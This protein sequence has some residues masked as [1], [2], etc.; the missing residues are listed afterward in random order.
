MINKFFYQL[1]TKEENIMKTKSIFFQIILYGIVMN[2][3]AQIPLNQPTLLSDQLIQ[4]NMEQVK[5]VRIPWIKN[6]GQQHE[7]VGYYART[8]AG[9][10]FISNK[11]EI[12]YSIPVEGKGSFAMSEIFIR[13]NQ[14]VVK[15]MKVNGEKPSITKVNYFIGNN[16]EKWRTNVPTFQS[17]QLG[18][19]WPGIKVKLKAH[20]NNIEKLFYIA[21]NAD[22]ATIRI[23]LTGIDDI[24]LNESGE[25][26][27]N[28]TEGNLAFSKPLAFQYINGIKHLVHV[29]Y[30]IDYNAYGF[31]VENFDPAYALVID[32]LI[33]STY[34]GGS[35]NDFCS[36]LAIDNL[37]NI[38]VT[39]YTESPDFPSSGYPYNG[40]TDIFICEL[41]NDLN[42]LLA[43]TFIGGTSYD[44]GFS[45]VLGSGGNI[46]ISG[47]TSSSNFPTT[48]GCFDNTFNGGRDNFIS[49]LSND[50]SILISS[51]YIGGSDYEKAYSVSL[52]AL[53]KVFIT[54][55]TS[56]SDYPTIIGSFSTTH[57]G[58]ND[59]F[60][61]KL[62][63]DLTVLESSTFIGGINDDYSN[64][65]KLDLFG[66]VFIGGETYSNN[67]P[68][69]TG[70]FST[71]L[72]GAND[73]F[74][75]KLDNGLG[76]VL[77]ATFVGGSESENLRQLKL[78][79]L[80]NIF[81][82]GNS[83]SPDYPITPGCYD[84][85]LNGF[86]DVVVSKLSN[87]LS[88]LLGSTFIGGS[89]NDFGTSIEFDNSGNIYVTGY[90]FSSDFPTSPNCYCPSMLG[91][92][93]AFI[94]KL[95]PDFDV[96]LAS[97]YIG[98]LNE[99]YPFS[100]DMDQ[101]GDL[102]IA[103][104]TDS[105]DYPTTPMA[106][107]EVN[108]GV[109]DVFLSKIDTCLSSTAGVNWSILDEKIIVYPVPAND[110]LYI[111]YQ[112]SFLVK[113]SDILG[114]KVLESTQ[115]SINISIL[116]D[117]VYLLHLEDEHGFIIH[118]QLIQVE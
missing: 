7:D 30:Y 48:T 91:L 84:P 73:L 31:A 29:D 22:P 36:D 58:L 107:D 94:S 110:V 50:L 20:G 11:G 115:K 75:A 6:I 88:T 82:V 53:G 60:V 76:S 14:K 23:Q 26:L 66:N 43:S 42:T 96:L 95:S 25:L 68:V 69:T 55:M 2:A 89:E 101:N 92:P 113:I 1:K 28:T 24:S 63:N 40:N 19:V 118:S 57:N 100:I 111:D 34:I 78:G 98:G 74:I 8:F 65:I 83:Y 109:F 18:E 15:K 41:S 17:V 80:Q 52:G 93:D 21:P 104:Y 51:T 90:T 97:T 46:F 56:S 99:D 44:A 87:D 3:F 106:Y 64:S 45:M 108:S 59:A 37:G 5:N 77:A 102:I 114:R 54:G 72:N 81:L 112:K 103:G 61:S 13:D 62:S 9:T 10:V 4:Q 79:G 105:P 117:G 39:G 38:Y 12:L 85:S 47:E 27:I 67:F 70:S 32:P 86:N 71:S 35:N 16:P 116:P 33:A 49:K